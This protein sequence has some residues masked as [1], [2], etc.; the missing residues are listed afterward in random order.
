MKKLFYAIVFMLILMACN[1]YGLIL[2]Y[3]H[4]T[5]KGDGEKVYEVV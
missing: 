4:K 3:P 2:K 5:V 1:D